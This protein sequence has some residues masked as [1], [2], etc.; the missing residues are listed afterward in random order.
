MG[1]GGSGNYAYKFM[2]VDTQTGIVTTLHDYSKEF[3]A[4]WTPKKAGTYKL[5]AYV[6]DLRDGSIKYAIQNYQISKKL[7]VSKV[8]VK[9]LA[10]LRYKVAVSATGT[11]PLKY[12]FVTVSASGKKTV[13]KNYGKSKTK[14]VKFKSKGKYI[15]YVYVKD[16][17]GVTKTVKKTVNV[18]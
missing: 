3:I 14:T 5:Y 18:K 13:V 16:G 8:S 6:K 9:R 7:S 17:S 4:N 1:K 10:K 15:V 12:K 11:N 2:V